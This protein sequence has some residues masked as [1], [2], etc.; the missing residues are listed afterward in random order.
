MRRRTV[1][2]YLALSGG[3]AAVPRPFLLRAQ[4]SSV[5]RGVVSFNQCGY[6][7]G[8][9]KVASVQVENTAD[10]TFQI[11]SERT[12]V[13]LFES[14][15]TP[16]TV[17]AAS[18]DRVSLAE[19][20][21]L[22]TPGSYRFVIQGTRS[23]P[24]IIRS[25]AYLNPLALSIRSFYG[26]RCGCAVDLGDGYHHAL[27]HADGAYHSSSGVSGPFGNHGGWHDAGD[28]GRYIVNSSITCG[29][30]LWAWELY[31]PML[32][33]LALHI[34]E[35]G[36]KL[37]DYLAEVRWNLEW[38]LSLQDT[39]GGVWHKQTS[40]HFCGMIMPEED[41]LTS[42]VIGTA[43]APYKSTCAT[44]GLSA[45]MAIAARCYSTYD[46]DFSSRCLTAAKHGWAWAVA[47]P[48]VA[49]VNPPGITTGAYADAH[50][51][52]EIL[53]A[54]AE[55]WRTTGDRQ[56]EQAFLEGSKSLPPERVIAAPSW[57]NVAP[58]A[59][60]TYVLADRK[61]SAALRMRILAQT[62]TAGQALLKQRR[63]SGYG[64]T[65]S[66]TD[67]GWGSNSVAANQSLLLILAQHLQAD[68]EK[69]EA[70]FANLH[71]LLGRN[72]FGVSW[73]THLGS[74]PF[75]H[76]HHRPSVAGHLPGPWPGLL[77]GGPNAN[78]SDPVGKSLPKQPPMRMW[79]DDAAAY[80]LN[81]IAINWNAPLVFLLA[82]AN[83]AA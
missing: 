36:G 55:L 12:G 58:F 28:Y 40:E 74:A 65:L 39:D 49:F 25:D 80:S 47:H 17:D 64:N 66:E 22:S 9:Q 76:P 33:N 59:Y 15:L 51:S 72:C 45:V 20:S 38:M 43:G 48:G 18:G 23:E 56:Y 42:Y 78:P 27:C 31:S 2:R 61:P 7:P 24:F 69:V 16:S 35:S 14:R 1:L 13:S 82:A 57:A 5:G 19:F 67:Y 11:I 68:G 6:L 26:Q 21:A 44:A 10:R 63:S 50:C 8:S 29:T 52:D 54:S 83:S 34:P 4:P 71:Y 77:S 53:W 32:S 37:P 60:W 62:E 41:R 79:A 75:V 81:E 3:A 46:A 73:V 30:L 70:A